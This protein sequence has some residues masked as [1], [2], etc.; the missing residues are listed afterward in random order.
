MQVFAR[1]ISQ[2]AQN[3]SL[4]SPGQLHY[5]LSARYK[6]GTN[7]VEGLQVEAEQI[8]LSLSHFLPQM[9]SSNPSWYAAPSD[10]AWTTHL[11][12]VKYC[13]MGQ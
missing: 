6:E 4:C 5:E 1:I 9:Q 2:M 7:K 10:S 12:M 13:T 8:D 3:K 11:Y